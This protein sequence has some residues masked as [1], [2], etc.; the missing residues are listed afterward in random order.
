MIYGF[1]LLFLLLCLVIGIPAIRQ[2]LFM[3]DVNKNGATT[4]GEVKSSKSAMGWLWMS[5]FGNQDRPLIRYQSP[6]G[7][8]M[9][10][11]VT[12]SSVLPKR[13]YEPGQTLEVRYD[14]SRPGRA[15]LVAEW[16]VIVR[17]LWLGSGALAMSIVLW[18]IGCVYNMPF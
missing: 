10:L 13:R 1:S 5:S 12:T 6:S 11:E 8:E 7:T 16:K 9:L 14:S 15:Y 3:Q 17:E 4:T 2:M 18:I